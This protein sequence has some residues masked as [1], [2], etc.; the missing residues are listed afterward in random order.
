MPRRTVKGMC[1]TFFG[2]MDEGA[3][4]VQL[5]RRMDERMELPT[6]FMKNGKGELKRL[7]RAIDRGLLSDERKTYL[8]QEH[9]DYILM[10]GE[11]APKKKAEKEPEPEQEVNGR[12]VTLPELGADTDADRP[13]A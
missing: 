5:Q 3:L 8:M 4:R 13:Q 2:R 6:G 11:Y 10:Q 1:R 7:D 9:I 12:D